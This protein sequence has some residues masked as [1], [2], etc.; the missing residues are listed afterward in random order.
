MIN[1]NNS[2]GTARL[3]DVFH[4]TLITGLLV[5][6]FFPVAP[7]LANGQQGIPFI[8][9]YPPEEYSAH[10]QNWSIVQDTAGIM[11]FGNT[12][13][14]VLQFDGV[15]WRQIPVANAS[16]V[17][18]LAIDS[19]G[20]IYV[21]AQNEIGY[22][23]PDSIGRLHYISLLEDIPEQF[24]Q[25]GDVWQILTDDSD[26]YFHTRKYLFRRDRAGTVRVWP[27]E[28]TFHSSFMPGNRK[29]Y[30]HQMKTGLMQLHQ[31]SLRLIPGGERF[32]DDW[33]YAVLDLDDG[34]LV[35][36]ARNSGLF[37]FDGE[38]IVP[39]A[40]E[41]SSWLQENLVYRGLRLPD[42][43]FIF[44]TL[45]GGI[46]HLSLDGKMDFALS[47][48]HGLQNEN[49]WDVFHGKDGGLWTAT[50]SG[51]SRI[52]YPGEFS[53][54][55][56]VNGL[57]GNVQQMV[58][59][60]DKIYAATSMGVYR[61]D[62]RSGVPPARF[63]YLADLKSQCWALLSVEKHLLVSSNY[64][65]HEI[66]NDQIRQI[67]NKSAWTLVPFPGD[68]NRIYL[69]LDDGI[70]TLYHTENGWMDEGRLPGFQAEARTLAF[71]ENNNLW[72]G[73]VYS[74]VYRINL[75]EGSPQPV[76]AE[77]GMADGLPSIHYNLV[78]KNGMS[79][80]FGT[81]HGIYRFDDSVQRF[82]PLPIAENGI[83]LPPDTT[84]Y[85]LISSDGNG[86]LWFNCGKKLFAAH[87]IGDN[88]YQLSGNYFSRLPE[89][90]VYTI[91][92]DGDGAV[93]FGGPKGL[94]R[95]QPQPAARDKAEFSVQ[96]RSVRFGQRRQ[97][98]GGDLAVDKLI[99]PLPYSNTALRFEF[100]APFFV[101]EDATRYRFHL[102]GFDHGYSDW[103]AETIKDYTNL[104]E[105]NYQFTVS[106]KN[107][108]GQISPAA[109][110]SFSIRPPWFRSN[111]A[112][113]LYGL[114]GMLGFVVVMN[115]MTK[116]AAQ[117]ALAER[118][119]TE[120]IEKAAEEKIQKRMA[121]DFHDELG[122]RITRITL[123]SE[124]LK[125]NFDGRQPDQLSYI[126]KINDN[127][128]SLYDETR[129]FIWQLDPKK[130][131]VPDL[132]SRLKKFGD[133]LFEAGEINFEVKEVKP[134][135]AKVR[136]TMEQRRHILRIF[137]E[138]M[139]NALK[140][141]GCKNVSFMASREADQIRFEL[142]D[143]GC[144]FDTKRNSTGNGLENM[145]TRAEAIA[146]RLTV[147]SNPG[148]GTVI[149]LAV[150]LPEQVVEKINKKK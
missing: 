20:V 141:A 68:P 102:E 119:K 15:T 13:G 105:G 4:I 44:T 140:Y 45:R 109:R 121:A 112:Y 35:I 40:P 53:R 5:L 80:L 83:A 142:A 31:D 63:E 133:E 106:A 62:S 111:W 134:A 107:V 18:S 103:T 27:A 9:N 34:N 72:V 85:T 33:V 138:G 147:R 98:F 74:G 32:V 70:A 41:A 96:I 135:L 58:R 16:I 97:L 110:F 116:R 108:F 60:R 30:I 6:V 88:Q 1:K 64:G 94:T 117:K 122:N 28:H 24:R 93:W 136:L 123:F 131:L 150:N 84:S 100:A 86:K 19:A 132:I 29:L 129:D 126:E 143:D 66:V 61:L 23:A 144:G 104:P 7:G 12:D 17:R 76:I 91:F 101:N 10:G 56:P 149:Q 125:N 37:R 115:R 128:H 92:P 90:P 95:W 81:T 148:A 36:A 137:Q 57:Q 11:Y 3:R 48:Q 25:F 65:V 120:A 51:I 124:I 118:L 89:T 2:T 130:D 145:A 26:I 47:K 52:E 113:L 127:A 139:H 69:G 59:Y 50:N 79:V 14:C 82:I 71:D 39:F 54:F 38:T 43:S 22:L 67:S 87:R 75:E 77:Y 146:A 78:F 46:M 73:T 55:S 21:G 8:K 49:V 99:R 114:T 42:G